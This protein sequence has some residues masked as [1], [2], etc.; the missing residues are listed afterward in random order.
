MAPLDRVWAES[1]SQARFAKISQV[2][3]VKKDLSTHDTTDVPERLRIRPMLGSL[4]LEISVSDISPARLKRLQPGALPRR[5][6][7]SIVKEP[8]SSEVYTREVATVAPHGAKTF[9]FSAKFFS[10]AVTGF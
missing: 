4:C 5:S 6:K 3:F 1:I 7:Y 2:R 10:N 9:G 8:V